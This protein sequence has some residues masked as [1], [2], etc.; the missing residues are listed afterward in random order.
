MRKATV[1]SILA[2]ALVLS[3]C[4]GT[5][6]TESATSDTANDAPTSGCTVGATDEIYVT[7]M[8]ECPSRAT[9]VYL[10]NTSTAKGDYWK[11]AAEFGSVKVAEGD[12]WLEVKAT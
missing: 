7:K 1:L 11:A 9:R 6:A 4:G 3:G 12:T 10:F 5:K 8:Y 2:G